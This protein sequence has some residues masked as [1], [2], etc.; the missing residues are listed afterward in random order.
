MFLENY[1]IIRDEANEIE[2]FSE[3]LRIHIVDVNCESYLMCLVILFRLKWCFI[4]MLVAICCLHLHIKII[5][6]DKPSFR[7]IL[8]KAIIITVN[9]S[10]GLEPHSVHLQ[11]IWIWNESVL[12]SARLV[13]WFSPLIYIVNCLCNS[14]RNSSA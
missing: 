1:G 8:H 13:K 3:P 14:K 6:R 5:I 2:T 12:E 7:F 11:L 4:E 10:I 9:T